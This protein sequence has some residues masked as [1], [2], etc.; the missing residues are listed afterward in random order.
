MRGEAGWTLA[1]TLTALC[2]VPFL[3]D[4]GTQQEGTQRSSVLK[5]RTRQ[6]REMNSAAVLS[7]CF[8]S[9]WTYFAINCTI[10]SCDA[11]E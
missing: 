7:N 10:G 3:E 8:R 4:S 5:G 2:L 9:N 1:E 11:N 6:V